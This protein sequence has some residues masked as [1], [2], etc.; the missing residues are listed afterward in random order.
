[1]YSAFVEG[2][3]GIDIAVDRGRQP[4]GSSEIALGEVVMR[5]LD[6]EVGDVVD[7][8]VPLDFDATQLSPPIRTTVTG[9]PI[10]VA[11]LYELFEPG[12]AAAVSLDLVRDGGYPYWS[13]F[14]FVRMREDAD[15]RRNVQDV[16][17]AAGPD[18]WFESADPANVAV[19]RDVRGLPLALVALLASLGCVTLLQRLV[20]GARANRRHLAVLRALGLTNRQ[21]VMA[22]AMQGVIV[23]V[24]VGATAVVIGVLAARPVWD[25]TADYLSVVPAHVVEVA[26]LAAVIGSAVAVAVATG[27]IVAAA[28]L[29]RAPAIHLRSE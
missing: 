20:I 21:L 7:V 26:P 16:A 28:P 25:W 18:Y 8:R 13:W 19:L 9:R 6:V 1:V 17:L 24:I 14:W 4:A 22:G 10:L 23:A 3:R 5:D 11:P 29:R 15:D 2:G 27:V 12:G